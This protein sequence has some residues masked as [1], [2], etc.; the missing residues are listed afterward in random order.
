MAI[1]IYRP[2]PWTADALCADHT[3]HD[4]DLWFPSE[5]GSRARLQIRAAKEVC[6][7]CPVQ[8]LCLE[9][10]LTD[11]HLEG[12]WGGK[13]ETERKHILKRRACA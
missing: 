11:P 7:D 13:T 2:M 3:A 5:N 4:P 12:I 1:F 6:I 9:A 8:A 10:A